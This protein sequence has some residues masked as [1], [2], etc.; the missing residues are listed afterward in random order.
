MMIYYIHVLLLPLHPLPHLVCLS[1]FCILCSS[2]AFHV[3]LTIIILATIVTF[4]SSIKEKGK[5]YV[6][7]C[8]DLLYECTSAVLADCIDYTKHRT[9]YSPLT[10]SVRIIRCLISPV[11]S[12]TDSMWWIQI[13]LDNTIRRLSTKYRQLHNYLQLE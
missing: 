4:Y 3:A 12:T 5:T 2:V 13:V 8:E 7:L 11:G 10:L 6:L 9:L 1:T